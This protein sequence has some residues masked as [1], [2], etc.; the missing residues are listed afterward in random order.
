MTR[1]PLCAL[2]MFSVH[3]LTAALPLRFEVNHGQSNAAVDFVAHS[4]SGTVLL[5]AQGAVVKARAAS[6]VFFDLAGPISPAAPEPLDPLASRS[7]YFIG[8]DPAQWRVNV[9]NFG[10]VRYRHVWPGIDLVYYG[11]SNR[12]EYDFIVAPGA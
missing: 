1:R 3:P 7:N 9:P 10:R 5:R 2:I 11:A 8:R 4:A 6:P 12:V